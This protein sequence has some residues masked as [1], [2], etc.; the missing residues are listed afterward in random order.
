MIEAPVLY[1]GESGVREEGQGSRIH[2]SANLRRGGVE[3]RAGLRHPL[4]FRDALLALRECILSRLYLTTEEILAQLDPVVT[5]SPDGVYFE[6]FSRDESLYG[7]VVVRPE[8]LDGLTA[9]SFGCTNVQFSE[10]LARGLRELR[11]RKPAC[12]EVGREVV[13]VE[14]PA[15]TSREVRIPLPEG[16]LQG[17]LEVQAAQRLPGTWL[18][19][20]PMDLAN[21]LNYL[22]A[23]KEQSS[24]RSLRFHLRPGESP[25]VVVEPWNREFQMRLS[26][27]DAP[28]E[29]EVRQWGRR[30]LLLLAGVL[31]HARQVRVLLQGTARPSFWLADLP[32]TSLL[33][34]LSPWCSQEWTVAEACGPFAAPVA[35]E[36]KEVDR[37]QMWLEERLAVGSGDL[38]GL[39]GLPESRARAAIDRLCLRGRV[40]YDLETDRYLARRLLDVEPPEPDATG[41]RREEA[42]RLAAEGRVAVHRSGDWLEGAV[43]GRGGTYA[44][45]LQVGPEGT[46]LSGACACPFFARFGLGRGPCKHLLAAALVPEATSAGG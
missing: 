44:V 29:Q 1:A 24:P 40:L 20:H 19:L 45:R 3:L 38:A 22:R 34:G 33:L 2:L 11:S 41:R 4:P 17:F 43:R 12:L 21:L 39:A 10:A 32:A 25:R 9:S 13:A 6:A 8:G 26:R 16:W 46:V 7:R 36:P 28:V 18:R 15:G 5:V 30:R 42:G 27:H 14:G 31:P 23:R 37:V 35:V